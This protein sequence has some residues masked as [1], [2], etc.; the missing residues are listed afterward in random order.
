MLGGGGGCKP[1]VIRREAGL[2][3][4]NIFRA[5]GEDVPLCS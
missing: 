1:H 4:R 2:M 5:V 3:G